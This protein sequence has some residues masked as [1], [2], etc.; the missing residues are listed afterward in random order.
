MP[1]LPSPCRAASER[2]SNEQST[3]AAVRSTGIRCRPSR[4]GTGGIVDRRGICTAASVSAIIVTHASAL[5]PTPPFALG[6]RPPW[7]LCASLGCLSGE[8][9]LMPFAPAG[10][11][12]R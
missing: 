3:R 5:P 10:G 8:L 1:P 12:K 11:F 6:V 2:R 7:L 4:I 9:M